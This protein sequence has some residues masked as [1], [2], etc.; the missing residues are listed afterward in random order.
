MIYVIFKRNIK[1]EEKWIYVN[2]IKINEDIGYGQP[3]PQPL[4][5]Y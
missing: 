2:L 5:I 4:Y 3:Q 1:I